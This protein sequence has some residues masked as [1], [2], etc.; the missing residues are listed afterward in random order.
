M[1]SLL[2]NPKFQ[3]PEL[4]EALLGYSQEGMVLVCSFSTV[5]IGTKNVCLKSRYEIWHNP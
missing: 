3:T 1:L 4:L 2:H 5:D